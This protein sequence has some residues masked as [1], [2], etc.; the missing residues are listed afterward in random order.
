MDHQ[1]NHLRQKEEHQTRLSQSALAGSTS[2]FPSAED[3]IR[4]DRNQTEPPPSLEQRVAQAVNQTPPPR[5]SWWAR[6]FGN[7]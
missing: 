5:R 1:P 4:A 6:L 3:A 7:K 2:E